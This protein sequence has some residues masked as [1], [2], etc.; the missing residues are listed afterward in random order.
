MKRAILMLA[1]VLAFGG[2]A[3]PS[4][5]KEDRAAVQARL[6]HYSDLLLA[7]DSRGIAMIF[8]PDGEMTNPKS[9]PVKGREA[10][11]KFIAGFSDFHVIS[12]SETPTSILIDGNTAEQMGDYHQKVRTPDGRIL[13]ISGRFEIEWVRSASGEWLLLQVAT[14]PNQ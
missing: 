3:A 5:V 2:C 7:M 10:I 9:P 14:F 8:T 13:E 6:Q 11:E 1:A 4:H 12:N